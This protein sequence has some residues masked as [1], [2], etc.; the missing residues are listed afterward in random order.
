MQK[1][2]LYTAGVI[3]AVA[4]VVHVVRLI[5]DVEIVVD[6]TVVPVWGSLPGAIIAALLAIWMLV[7]ARRS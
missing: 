6:G 4:S 5:R 2:A 1:P 7:A 3:F